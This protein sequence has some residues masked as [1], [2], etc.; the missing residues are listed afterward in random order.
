VGWEY[1]HGDKGEEEVWNVE[2]SE[3]GLGGNKIWSVKNKLI[4]KEKRRHKNKH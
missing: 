2:Q 4:K 3:G 1:P